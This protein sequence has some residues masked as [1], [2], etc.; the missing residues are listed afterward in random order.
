[1]LI[2]A[3]GEAVTAGELHGKLKLDP[4]ELGAAGTAGGLDLQ[5]HAV[6]DLAAAMRDGT[7]RL[8]ADGT[9][10]VTGGTAPVP[11]LIGDAAHLTVSAAAAGSNVTIS[12]FEIDGRKITAS[13]AGSLAPTSLA[14]DW[15]LASARSDERITDARW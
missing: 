2:T 14:F 3:D 6:L 1:M 12:R 13:A 10:A 4:S 9:V 15:R 7:T 11:A 8:D 5:G